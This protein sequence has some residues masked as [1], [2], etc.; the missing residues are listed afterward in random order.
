MP[1]RWTATENGKDIFVYA[2]V[3]AGALVWTCECFR[4]KVRSED[5]IH[6]TAVKESEK[7]SIELFEA[8]LVDL[9]PRVEFRTRVVEKEVPIYVD[10][11][12][13]TRDL[14]ERDSKKSQPQPA[15]VNVKVRRA[16]HLEGAEK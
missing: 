14:I 15:I 13:K 2:A 8:M 1:A 9:E 16:I 7:R 3:R 4:R 12:N 10:N 11:A 5:C 6:I